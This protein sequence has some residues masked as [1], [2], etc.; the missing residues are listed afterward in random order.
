[1]IQLAKEHHVLAE[2]RTSEKKSGEVGE[3]KKQKLK[4]SKGGKEK[5]QH[6][7]SEVKQTTKKEK[8]KKSKTRHKTD[9]LQPEGSGTLKP[10]PSLHQS[11]AEPTMPKGD[12]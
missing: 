10:T 8:K 11:G 3:G 2:D 12:D 1:M 7:G 6:K 4:K 5:D 9:G